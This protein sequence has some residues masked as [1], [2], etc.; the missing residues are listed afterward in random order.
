MAASSAL[1][2]LAAAIAVMF[3][4]ALPGGPPQVAVPAESPTA[5]AAGPPGANPA[6]DPAAACAWPSPPPAPNQSVTLQPA[7][8]RLPLGQSDTVPTLRYTKAKGYLD[9]HGHS[10]DQSSDTPFSATTRHTYNLVRLHLDPKGDHLVPYDHDLVT[11]ESRATLQVGQQLPWTVSGDPGEGMVEVA[12]TRMVPGTPAEA[13]DPAG[14]CS[15]PDWKRFCHATDLSGHQVNL[16]RHDDGSFVLD[17]QQPDGEV[18]SV[19]VDPL[20]PLDGIRPL[21]EMGVSLGDV[22]AL[23][24]D[25]ALDVVG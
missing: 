25:P 24:T 2:A 10:L 8:G 20:L 3:T 16:G 9:R 6:C 7:H 4:L 11:G 1:T 17:Y 18:A 19:R 23:L 15:G 14:F 22:M 21:K 5:D 13:R 12:V